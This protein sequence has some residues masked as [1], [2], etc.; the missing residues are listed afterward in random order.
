[1]HYAI[2]AC[3]GAILIAMTTNM[4]HNIWKNCEGGRTRL[5]SL[6]LVPPLVCRRFLRTVGLAALCLVVGGGSYGQ[7]PARHPLDNAALRRMQKA[8]IQNPSGRQPRP[9]GV[10]KGLPPHP[11][12]DRVAIDRVALEL[13]RKMIR[14]S[15]DYTGEMITQVAAQNNFPL[16]QTIKGDRQ[17]R[18]LVTFLNG[19]LV[20]DILLVTPGEVRNYHRNTG[21]MEVAFWPTEWDDHAKRMFAAIRSGFYTARVMGAEQ[22]AGR[23][24][25]IVEL[26]PVV[27][28]G[29]PGRPHFKFWI[30]QENG[31]QLKNEKSDAMG[32]VLSHR[33]LTSIAVGSTAVTPQDFNLNYLKQAQVVPLFP[34][35]SQYRSLEQAQ[36]HL[37]FVPLVPVTLPTG[38]HLGGVWVIPGT[39]NQPQFVLL[40]YTDDVTSFSLYERIVPD[41]GKLPRPPAF[42]RHIERWRIALPHDGI[43]ATYTG[44]LTTG[45]VRDIYSSL[46]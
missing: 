31:V 28:V 9:T 14:P 34:P 23:Q 39:N 11:R 38:F 45:Q 1:M 10:Q 33:Y 22:V 17:G 15:T 8:R 29:E 46:H 4:R 42:N 2:E 37:P 32:R 6:L 44:M 3:I 12:I 26:L 19:S 21:I 27:G 36:G 30:D 40:R 18:T 35:N 20:G 41:Q 16:Q 43:E 13:L 24:A 7:L 5:L 25:S